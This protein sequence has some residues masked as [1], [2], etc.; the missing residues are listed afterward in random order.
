M[1]WVLMIDPSGEVRL[2]GVPDRLNEQLLREL[3][4]EFYTVAPTRVSDLVM[5]LCGEPPE[6]NSVAAELLGS[7][8][9]DNLVYGTAWVLRR[10][11]NCLCGL[12]AERARRR[13]AELNS[14]RSKK[15]D[16]TG[17]D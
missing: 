17:S 16:G 15:D 6:E 3:V 9:E 8:Y 1:K 7:G 14:E 13:C 11:G 4:G 12:S 5:V 10:N 2:V